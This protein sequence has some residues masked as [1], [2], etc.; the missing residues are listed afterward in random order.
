MWLL[1]FDVILHNLC[2]R[3]N[4]PYFLPFFERK[5]YGFSSPPSLDMNKHE[6]RG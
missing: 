2:F 3:D 5:M 1:A 6:Y 4:I